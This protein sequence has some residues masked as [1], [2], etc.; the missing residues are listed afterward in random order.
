MGE[1]LYLAW[2]EVGFFGFAVI[3]TWWA[4][5]RQDPTWVFRFSSVSDREGE[6]VRKKESLRWVWKLHSSP[7]HF[8][9]Y[10][11]HHKALHNQWQSIE[12]LQIQ[13]MDHYHRFVKLPLLRQRRQSRSTE[14]LCARAPFGAPE[15]CGVT[16]SS[17]R[18]VPNRTQGQRIWSDRSSSKPLPHT[19]A[20]HFLLGWL[21]LA[22]LKQNKTVMWKRIWQKKKKIRFHWR[23][24]VRLTGSCTQVVSVKKKLTENNR[25]L[26]Q[27]WPLHWFL[28]FLYR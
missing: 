26:T 8:I 3:L 21:Q 16:I 15:A 10:I 20:L 14:S 17:R 1:F 11:L 2:G 28:G 27:G 18:S 24:S 22:K 9:F 6:R 25:S 5:E 7:H 13:E 4:T 23:E 19:E 12:G